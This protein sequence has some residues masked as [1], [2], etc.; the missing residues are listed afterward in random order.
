MN[1]LRVT[2]RY[3]DSGNL[4]SCIRVIEGVKFFDNYKVIN[5]DINVSRLFA[6]DADLARLDIREVMDSLE[7]D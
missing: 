1:K 6:T 2:I 5:I 7:Q 3:Q 4:F